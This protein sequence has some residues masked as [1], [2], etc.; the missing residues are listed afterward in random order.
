MDR[1]A[2]HPVPSNRSLPHIGEGPRAMVKLSDVSHSYVY[3]EIESQVLRNVDLEIA[4]GEFAAVLGPSGCGKTTLL[5]LLGGLEKP[6]RGH[7]DVDGRRITAFAQ[8]EISEYRRHTVS[9]IFQAYNLLPNLT[10]AENVA[11]GLEVLG[12]PRAEIRTRSADYLKAVGLDGQGGKFPSQLSGGMQQR[13]A[14][15]RA[16]AKHAKLILADEP[17]GNLDQETGRTVMDLLQ[18][19][20]RDHDSTLLLITHDAAVAQRADRILRI[21]NGSILPDGP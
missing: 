4:R 6:T 13:V 15:A 14:I 10:A 20:H 5:N 7:I 9:F 1:K 17:T 12:L 18:R 8:K 19:V 21:G 11:A 16:L 3:G 2:A